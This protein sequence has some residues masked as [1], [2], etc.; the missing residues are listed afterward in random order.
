MTLTINQE[1][2]DRRQLKV[3]VEV[4]EERVQ[5]A[6]R[7]H[8]RKLARQI[9]IPGFRKGK[10]PYGVI[11][12]YFGQE[13]V[14]AD[15]TEEMV[16]AVYEEMIAEIDHAPYAQPS[17]NDMSIEP[18]TLSFTIPLE[19]VVELGDYRAI[20]KD[21]EAV[22]IT[23]EAVEE[24]L[25][26]VRTHHT[27]TEPVDRPIEE[28]DV[29]TLS[30]TG[31]CPGN[32]EEEGAEDEIETIV[33]FDEERVELVMDSEALFAGTPFV[34]NLIGLEAGDSKEFSFTFADDHDDEDVAGRVANFEI[35]I[36]D[37][38]SRI[39][40]ELTDE[41][42]QEEEGDYETV[43]E[44]REGLQTQLTTQAE[45]QA[46]SDLL[47]EFIEE[48]AKDATIAYPPAALEQELDDMQENLKQQT[49]RS[50]WEW[51]DY[52]RLQ[53]KTEET[54]REE[55]HEA[56]TTRLKNGLVVRE[57][58]RTEKVKISDEAFE[59]VMQERLADIDNEEF[60]TQ[61]REFYEGPGREIIAN[62]LLM[63]AFHQRVKAIATGNAPD[64]DTEE[65]DNTS[66][67]TT[68][69]EE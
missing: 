44:L 54:L 62:G 45:E 9:N 61:M 16:Q 18:L 37:V 3:N 52:L 6:M 42:A 31:E 51:E 58:I 46:K 30:G 28:T 49:T 26:H 63:D 36:L 35:T 25:E 12:K 11:L 27:I 47:D 24:A 67:D 15:A 2:D 40:P 64:L 56:A 50:G 48:M 13:A 10:A 1:E 55:W 68:D 17:M 39:V 60:Q 19:P 69:E 14:R 66:S 7:K 32:E 41:I 38:Q 53:N 8:A 23:E 57:F 65:T 59:A 20:R 22:E 5:Q 4:A 21:I 34:E 33:L 43:E 29:V